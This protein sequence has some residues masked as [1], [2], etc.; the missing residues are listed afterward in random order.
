M[1]YIKDLDEE[2]LTYLD[3][4]WDAEREDGFQ[5]AE[6]AERGFARGR[7]LDGLKALCWAGTS[8]PVRAAVRDVTA[9]PLARTGTLGADREKMSAIG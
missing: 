7:A 9:R 2:P 4:F 8:S 5:A 1:N 3:D 6:P